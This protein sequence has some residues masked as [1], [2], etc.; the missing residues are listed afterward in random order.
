MRPGE[1]KRPAKALT[2]LQA[3]AAEQSDPRELPRFMAAHKCRWLGF[4]PI[5]DNE[6][7]SLRQLS[8]K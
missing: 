6:A 4:T 2:R 3:A 7:H 5:T 8:L 1:R